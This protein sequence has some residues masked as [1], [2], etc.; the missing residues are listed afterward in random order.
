[1]IEKNNVSALNQLSEENLFQTFNN[2]GKRRLLFV[3]NSIT[4]HGPKPEIGWEND[5]G[6]AAS[7]KENDYVHVTVAMLEKIEGEIDYCI[8]NCGE[9]ETEYYNEK[10]LEKYFDVRDFRADTIIIRI[11]ENIWNARDKFQEY[12]LEIYFEKLV[13]FFASCESARVIITGMFW[14]HEEI[15][16]S[17]EVV[18]K[19][20]GVPFVKLDDLCVDENMAIGQYAHGGVCLHPND[21]GMRK[22]AERIVC[23]I[24]NFRV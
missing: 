3:G 18:A 15:E 13:K 11:G 21:E 1:M 12:S 14:P 4:R 20:M 2:A 22:I 5:W 8:V 24:N 17:L 23:A 7:K 16:A 6:M 9:W 10:V 19:K